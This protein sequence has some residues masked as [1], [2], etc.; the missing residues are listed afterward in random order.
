[1]RIEYEQVVEQ[2]SLLAKLR[3]FNP[4]LI[5][6]PPLGIELETSDIDVACSTDDLSKFKNVALKEFGD[7]DRF[8]YRHA[9]LQGQDSVVVQFY[10]YEWEVELFCQQTPTEQQWGVR[11]FFVEQKILEIAPQLKE[12]VRSLKRDGLKTEPAFAN[13]LGLTG[14]PYKS[15]LAL[16]KLSN[17]DLANIIANRP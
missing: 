14:D 3:E 4:I 12:V 9:T 6:T 10:A 7:S 1:M 15:I 5:G 16:E 17:E 8:T 13:V 2:L 11:H